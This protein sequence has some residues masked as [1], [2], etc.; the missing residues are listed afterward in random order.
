MKYCAACGYRVPD[1]EQACPLCGGKLTR[2]QAEEAPPL[3]THEEAGERCVLPNQE[4]TPPRTARMPFQPR[5]AQVPPL[6][7]VMLVLA[8]FFG[9]NAFS[10]LL[11]IAAGGAAAIFGLVANLLLASMFVDLSR[12]PP[13]SQTLKLRNGREVRVATLVL[14]RLVGAILAYLVMYNLA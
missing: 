3:H 13:G 5:R 11:G 12:V 4:K 6:R 7:T 9:I 10:S 2:L 1:F 14:T 8:V